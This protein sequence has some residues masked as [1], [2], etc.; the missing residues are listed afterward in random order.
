M[1]K[2]SA[3]TE[4]IR[5]ALEHARDELTA[6]RSR[7]AQ[8]AP[9]F[10]SGNAGVGF[11]AQGQRIADALRRAHAAGLQR[12][13]HRIAHLEALRALNEAI[14]SNDAAHAEDLESHG[15]L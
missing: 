1:T 5:A 8:H 10:H 7:G 12:V 13:D 2:L 9:D 11:A 15:R 4:R 3:D 14:V 6:T